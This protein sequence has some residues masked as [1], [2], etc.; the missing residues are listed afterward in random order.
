MQQNALLHL[1]SLESFEAVLA[2]A[3]R[4]QIVERRSEYVVDTSVGIDPPN[5]AYAATRSDF[6]GSLSGA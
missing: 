3:H 4:A 2:D 6:G 1:A 5:L